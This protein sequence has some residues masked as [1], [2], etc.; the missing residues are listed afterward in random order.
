MT[1]PRHSSA[2][3]PRNTTPV[4][5]K[6]HLGC[7][8]SQ[9]RLSQEPKTWK[10]TKHPAWEGRINRTGSRHAREYYPAIKADRAQIQAL[11]H[12]NLENTELSE[13]NQ[14]QRAR[15][16]RAP[17]TRNAEGGLRISVHPNLIFSPPHFP[18]GNH[19]FVLCVCDSV[20]VSLI[21]SLVSFFLASTYKCYHLF[22]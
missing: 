3:T 6:Q 2:L 18:F 5:F 19:K 12:I 7:V 13:R 22:V 1:R 9:W 14:L 16:C 8:F 10:H 20:S 15:R 21:S 17:C 4:L 11:L